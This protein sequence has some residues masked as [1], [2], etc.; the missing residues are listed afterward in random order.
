MQGSLPACQA[1]DC[2]YHKLKHDTARRDSLM[3]AFIGWSAEQRQQSHA[4]SLCVREREGRE[5]E[6]HCDLIF[7]NVCV[8]TFMS[9]RNVEEASVT[10]FAGC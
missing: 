3:K 2:N 5:S 1:D 7:V 10:L 9:Y 4:A 8:F 6:D